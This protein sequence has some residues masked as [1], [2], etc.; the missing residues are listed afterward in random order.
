MRPNTFAVWKLQR[1]GFQLDLSKTAVLRERASLFWFKNRLLV[2]SRGAPS[3][4]T[5]LK[6]YA[7]APCFDAQALHRK[8]TAVV[9]SLLGR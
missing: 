2:F 8:V 7:T 3:T 6:S 1:L 9:G 5:A 4:A